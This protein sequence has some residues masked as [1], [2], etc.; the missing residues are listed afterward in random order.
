MIKN[1]RF[2]CSLALPFVF[3]SCDP[4]MGERICADPF[5]FKIV[6][7]ITQKDVVFETPSKYNRDSVYLL[8]TL[9]GYGGTRAQIDSL[10]FTNSLLIPV[11]TFF[12]Q[13]NDVDTDTLLMKYD[14]LKTSCCQHFGILQ[15]IKYNGVPAKQQGKIFVFEK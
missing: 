4:C 14:Y 6:D 15:S 9:P 10:K 13:L 11:D 5:S 2:F 7:R 3:I 8:T 12:L 1:L